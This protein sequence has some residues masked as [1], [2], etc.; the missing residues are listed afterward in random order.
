MEAV[1]D[2]SPAPPP[3]P[4]SAGPR[5]HSATDSTPREQESREHEMA[6]KPE[7]P[8]ASP[9]GELKQNPNGR[10]AAFAI[11]VIAIPCDAFFL[12]SPFYVK[13]DGELPKQARSGGVF[14]WRRVDS[15]TSSRILHPVVFYRERSSN[16]EI[17]ACEG[18]EAAYSEAERLIYF[19]FSSQHDDNPVTA[20]VLDISGSTREGQWSARPSRAQME[21][22]CSSG[23]GQSRLWF[24]ISNLFWGE[25]SIWTWSAADRAVVVD[26]DGTITRTSVW[27]Y[28][29]TVYLGSYEY[30]HSGCVTFLRHMHQLGYKI[31]Y[32]S[33]RPLS[34]VC[35][36]RELLRG[37]QCEAGGAAPRGPLMTNR[38]GA[39]SALYMEVVSQSTGDFKHSVLRNIC[40]LFRSA[41]PDSRYKC[42]FVW[43]IGNKLSDAEAYFCSGV[44]LSRILIVDGSGGKVI[45]GGGLKPKPRMLQ[46]HD[47]GASAAPTIQPPAQT[48]RLVA[49]SADTPSTQVT[50]TTTTTAHTTTTPSAT[51]R[52]F[53]S[54]LDP[55][56]LE[57]TASQPDLDT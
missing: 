37:I 53:S 28:L 40:D 48:N 30:I 55:E 15:G 26:I 3:P 36:T 20:T 9:I 8:A 5:T 6:S 51:T 27:G 10:R 33:A 17:V 56:L 25:V 43:G 32:L 12:C 22:L 34:H 52:I 21:S 18:V 54:Y 45:V 31:L 11:D 42:P 23:T 38:G 57:Y 50:T 1:I 14:N 47:Q 4:P 16:A 24:E 44:P 49:T 41:S 19:R 35:E 2:P 13:L 7:D 29:Q 39:T 46:L